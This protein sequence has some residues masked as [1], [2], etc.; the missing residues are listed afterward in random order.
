M[1]HLLNPLVCFCIFVLSAC[2]KQD[3]ILAT[4]QTKISP[5][6]I[7]ASFNKNEFKLKNIKLYPPAPYENRVEDYSFNYTKN[8]ELD[9]ISY[10]RTDQTPN[11]ESSYGYYFQYYYKGSKLDSINLVLTSYNEITS[12]V[13][14][15]IVYRGNKIISYNMYLWPYTPENHPDILPWKQSFDKKGRLNGYGF[16]TFIYDEDDFIISSTNTMGSD[17]NA[18]YTYERT[19]NPLFI[20]NVYLGLDETMI[21]DQSF[22]K[23]NLISKISVGIPPVLYNNQ[24]DNIGRLIERTFIYW[25]QQY[26]MTYYYYE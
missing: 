13:K 16:E 3:P 14:K 1:K 8:G 22:C 26:R 23:W 21:R 12:M 10:K 17:L 2:T 25:G 15:D 24:Y 11:G 20:E 5:Q 9:R 6:N 18:T 4:N 7:K 19:A